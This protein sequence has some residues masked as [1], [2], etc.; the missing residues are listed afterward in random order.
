MI[1][2]SYGRV[3]SVD[4][5]K[6]A[7]VVEGNKKTFTLGDQTVII[8]DN[9]VDHFLKLELRTGDDVSIFDIAAAGNLTSYIMVKQGATNNSTLSIGTIRRIGSVTLVRKANTDI[10]YVMGNA[11]VFINMKPSRAEDLR[12]DEPVIIV[13]SGTKT[14]AYVFGVYGVHK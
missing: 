14:L 11:K 1:S 7:F 3:K 9:R 4:A 12:M 6:R 10:D 5:A 13:I 8:R 2:F